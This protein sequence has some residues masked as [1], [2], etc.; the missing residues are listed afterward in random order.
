MKSLTAS[1][2]R[3]LDLFCGAGGAAM[4]LHRA[5]PQ[6]EITGVDIIPQPRYPFR[7]IQADAMSF[8]LE[9]FD[10]IWASPPCQRYARI[11]AVHGNREKHPDLIEPVRAAL[12]SSGIPWVLENVPDSKMENAV[13]LCGSMFGLGAAGALDGIPRQ[14]RR[15]RL[16]RA[17]FSISPPACTHQGEPIGVYGRGGPQR[18][19]RNRGYMGGKR[20]RE[21]AMEINWMERKELSNAIPPAYSEYIARAFMDVSTPRK[22]PG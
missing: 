16:F 15:H 7:F 10:F 8:P 4:G 19:G 14:L 17:S 22:D 12:E 6:A 11:G 3:I 20:E 2:L 5:W 1:P 9:G 13:T 21:E 18:A